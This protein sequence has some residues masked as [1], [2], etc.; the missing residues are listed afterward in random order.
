[1]QAQDV[2]GVVVAEAI[3]GDDVPEWLPGLI[4]RSSIGFVGFRRHVG[5]V[6]PAHAHVLPADGDRD[7]EPDERE[8]EVQRRELRRPTSCPRWRPA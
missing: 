3:A 2:A 7:R 5:D 8:R 6:L 4:Q 1:M